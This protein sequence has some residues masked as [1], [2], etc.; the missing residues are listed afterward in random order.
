MARVLVALSGGVDSALAA[1]LLVEQGHD[2]VAVHLKLAD[3]PGTEQVPGQGCCTLDDA[4]DARRTAQQ[5]DLPFYVWDLSDLFRTQV[6][7]PF[8][9]G[10]RDGLT[11]NPCITCNEKVKYRGL[12][13]RARQLGF[14]AL[15]TGHHVRLRRGGTPG[16]GVDVDHLDP[17]VAPG[18]GVRLFRAADAGKDQSYVLYVATPDDLAHTL[19]PVGEMTKERV[20]AEAAARGLSRVAAKPDSYEICFVPD[21]DTAAYLDRHLEPAPGPIVDL[22]GHVLGEH[23]GTWHVTVGQ[24]R[25]LGLDHHERRFVVDVDPAANTVVVGAR[26]AL[27][28]RWLELGE[29]TWTTTAGAPTGE[30]QVQ[31]RAHGTPVP[32]RLEGS[33][34]LLDEALYGVATGQAA[35]LYLG[36]ECLG[37]ATITAAERPSWSASLGSPAC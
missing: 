36:Q 20:R 13:D 33:R 16:D 14:D 11:P 28:C 22:D 32:G 2:V 7:E 21:G 27:A 18:P 25:G 10:W 37:G 19:F 15:A 34:V 1:A 31:V 8:A 30:V 29:V 5:L 23:H 9:R 17:V 35:V 24:R 4:A 3:L 12:L 6:Q 26:E